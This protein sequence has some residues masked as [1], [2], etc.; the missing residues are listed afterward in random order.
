M[1]LAAEIR[2]FP[3]E[4]PTVSWSG[5]REEKQVFCQMDIKERLEHLVTHSRIEC[6]SSPWSGVKDR[7]QADQL[8]KSAISQMKAGKF[9]EAILLFNSAMRVA[10]ASEDEAIGWI[11]AG[12]SLA[13]WSVGC[14]EES[15]GD[16]LAAIRL[17]P[18]S[19]TVQKVKLWERMALC[20]PDKLNDCTRNIRNQ[21]KL[22]T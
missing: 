17:L 14:L 18:S 22:L 1:K 9:V 20:K 2:V 12:R 3:D 6:E 10:P 19:F 11:C 16:C 21:R 8:R 13:S 15:Y 4:P 5:G 7:S